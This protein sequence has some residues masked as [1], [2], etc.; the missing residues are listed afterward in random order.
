MVALNLAVLDTAIDLALVKSRLSDRV[1]D[2]TGMRPLYRVHD[3]RPGI[4]VVAGFGCPRQGSP[5]QVVGGE[6]GMWAQLGVLPV[7]ALGTGLGGPAAP[8]WTP[9]GLDAVADFLGEPLGYGATLTPVPVNAVAAERAF[10][11]SIPRGC[12]VAFCRTGES[13]VRTIVPISLVVAT[14]RAVGH[15][16][17]ETI[18]MLDAGVTTGAVAVARP[19]VNYYDGSYDAAI[20]T[21]SW[22]AV[23]RDYVSP[24]GREIIFPS[25]PA[26]ATPLYCYANLHPWIVGWRYGITSAGDALALRFTTHALAAA[27]LGAYGAANGPE[28]QFALELQRQS[29]F[30]VRATVAL[31]KRGLDLDLWPERISS[32]ANEAFLNDLRIGASTGA[33]LRSQVLSAGR[34]TVFAAPEATT[35]PGVVR[36]NRVGGV[37]VT[38]AHGTLTKQTFANATLKPSLILGACDV[39]RADACQELELLTGCSALDGANAASIGDYFDH[40]FNESEYSLWAYH[41]ASGPLMA[42]LALGAVVVAARCAPN[43]AKDVVD[44]PVGAETRLAAFLSQAT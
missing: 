4:A 19:S 32:G 21:W 9:E 30:V 17:W 27:L 10:F 43:P 18:V 15:D 23:G 24:D 34:R 38:T 35:V 20:A 42:R 13:I 41:M 22:R 44:S 28:R 31:P 37:F 1:S 2:F 6:S 33:A 3:G 29:D 26:G 5:S 16:A 11:D 39:D 25:G 14:Y 40:P 7:D 8:V 36:V 12:G